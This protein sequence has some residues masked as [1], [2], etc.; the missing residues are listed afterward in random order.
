MTLDGLFEDEQQSSGTIT[1]KAT[2]DD[3]NNNVY[4]P[5]KYTVNIVGTATKSK[6]ADNE[7]SSSFVLTLV[8]PCD[9]P[10]SLIAGDAF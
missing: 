7:R 3:Y 9:P 10:L 5:G 2:V 6:D 8:D 1:F 4:P